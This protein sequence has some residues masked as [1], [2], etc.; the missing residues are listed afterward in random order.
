MLDTGLLAAYLPEFAPLVS[1]AQHDIY[2]V[3]TVDRHLLQ[4]VRELHALEEEEREI[5]QQV[6]CR[7]VLYLAALLHDVGKG[8]GQGH[9]E[10]GVAIVGKMAERFGL[11]SEEREILSFLVGQHLFLM[12]TA[13]RR[14]LEDEAMIVRC[15]GQMKSSDR[16][17]MLYLLTV[18]D[19][20]ATGPTVWNDWKAALLLELYL[21]IAHLL[22][23]SDLETQIVDQKQA[24]AWM[25][26]Q[27]GQQ[28]GFELPADT[29]VFPSDY[30]VSFT[31]QEV[32]HHLQLQK[33][34]DER[35]LLIETRQE[36]ECWSLLVMTRD[37]PGLLAKICGVLALHN[38]RILA[39]QIFTWND[40]TVVDVL[41][42]SPTIN[43]RYEEQ[44]WQKLEKDLLLAVRQ[45]LGLDYRLHKKLEPLGGKRYQVSH[46]LPTRVEVDNEGSDTCSIVEVYAA[47][48]LGLLYEIARTLADFGMNIY[49]AIIG[50]KAD[51]VVDVFY[52]QDYEGQKITD[53]QF[54]EEL[55]KGLLH[56]ATH[57]SRQRKDL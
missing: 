46:R 9:A 29:K 55:R 22:D 36:R 41:Q 4:T 7:Q 43:S 10:R 23:R 13:L 11:D 6:S 3:N 21:K 24:A 37:R 34:L 48:R 20:K 39:A 31:P 26:E 42:V 15:A 27:V 45:R 52:V 33:K 14:D 5:F 57:E 49:R 12:H 40:G 51:Q 35:E 53:P 2:H 44:D 32:A 1:L 54:Q 50:S 25:L 18:A 56:A 30:L 38:L 17:S 16:L 28:P 47:D 8:H 19:A